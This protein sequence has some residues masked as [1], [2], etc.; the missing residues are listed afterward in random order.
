MINITNNSL[1]LLILPSTAFV[2]VNELIPVFPDP[3]LILL[4]RLPNQFTS[5]EIESANTV[6]QA[7]L[8]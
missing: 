7:L 3:L 2:I 6:F 5:F 8:T 4:S 1:I